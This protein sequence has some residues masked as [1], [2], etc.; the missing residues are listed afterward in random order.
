MDYLTNY[1]KNQCQ[2]L[3]ERIVYLENLLKEGVVNPP[4]WSTKD[5]V[6][7]FTTF[8]ATKKTVE[9]IK[10]PIET[11][12]KVGETAQKAV[13]YV[14]KHPVKST[15]IAIGGAAA[16][17]TPLLVGMGAENLADTGLGA[18]GMEKAEAGE[19][20]GAREAIASGAGWAAMEGTSAVAA[21]LLAK[22]ALTA[23]LG[24]ALG[25]GAAAGLLAPA[26]G[27]GAYK[28]GEKIG[29][30]TGLHDYLRKQ[31]GTDEDSVTR[32]YIKDLHPGHKSL[33]QYPAL[34]AIQAQTNAE[35]EQ[36]LNANKQT[37]QEVDLDTLSDDALRRHIN[38][39]NYK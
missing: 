38:N 31:M 33:E 16:L 7:Q 10:H 19:M 2:Y 9:V 39:I 1:Y 29:E 13:S 37:N 6:K 27:Y 34:S 21:N 36:A 3:E 22:R 15:G 25:S 11:A 20:P 12:K 8:P 24:T 17:G 28:A 14:R 23:G 30:V 32:D 18:L 5:A 26:V 4:F 35:R